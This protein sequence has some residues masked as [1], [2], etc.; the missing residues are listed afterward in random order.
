MAALRRVGHFLVSLVTRERQQLTTIDALR[1][2]PE[3]DSPAVPLDAARRSQGAAA[4]RAYYSGDMPAGLYAPRPTDRAAQDTLLGAV[5]MRMSPTAV[6][7]CLG[8]EDPVAG[9]ATPPQGPPRPQTPAFS[10]RLAGELTL[11]ELTA[12]YKRLPRGQAPGEDGLLCECY[13]AFWRQLAPRL[14]AVLNAAIHSTFAAPLPLSMRSG[15]I[16]LLYKGKGA[17][18]TRPSSYRPITLLNCDYKVFAAAIAAR[19]G[20]PLGSVVDSSQTAFLPKRWIGDNVLAHS[21]TIDY[22]Q[23][24]GQP[25]AKV[26]LDLAKAFDRLDRAW[27]LRSLTALGAPACITRCSEAPV[28]LA[29]LCLPSFMWQPANPWLHIHAAL[30]LRARLTLSCCLRAP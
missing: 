29:A 5:D 8:T 22:L 6:A 20:A 15:R 9:A 12:V 1:C 23:T 4:L 30:R 24:S 16:M 14:L 28:E 25:G 11:D 19:L 18:R 17:D 10:A 26:Y 27:I 3:P 21:E 7:A 2:G 13:V